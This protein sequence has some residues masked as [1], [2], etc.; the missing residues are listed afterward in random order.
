MANH[1]GFG[2]PRISN[3][4]LLGSLAA[5]A[6]A[7]QPLSASASSSDLNSPV[8]SQET[9]ER[10]NQIEQERRELHERIIETRQKE[11]LALL[12]LGHINTKLNATRDEL[13]HNTKKLERTE[14]KI[15]QCEQ[16]I[17]QTRTTEEKI[18]DT[19]AERLK[20]IY[21]GER[22]SFIEMVFQVDSLRSLID[23][24]YFQERVAEMDKK[25]LEELKTKSALLEQS[26]DK[27]GEQ[28]KNLGDVVSEFAKKAMQIAKE[29]F[30]Q[31]QTAEKLKT[32]RAFYEQAEKQLAQESQRLETEILSM[33]KSNRN[34]NKN[35][36]TGSGTLAM[37]LAA[38]ITSPFGWRRHPIFGV[39]KFHTG[40]DLAGANHSAIRAADSGSVLYTG[41]YGGYGKVVIVSHGKGLA[42]LY[43]HMSKTA[44]NVN[45]NVQ[46]GD[47]VGYEGTTGF[48][49]GPH[50]HFEVRVN[51]KPNNPLNFLK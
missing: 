17:N 3:R 35:M 19:A 4:I 23:R 28:K 6:V 24:M 34:A 15:N 1:F 49:T 22:L 11:Q 37:P 14:V 20:Q 25:V 31:E 43:A 44:V 7:L 12:K 48:S 2:H 47:I 29:K 16:N 30:A 32:Q 45:Q 18:S 46:K 27:L 41:W 51:G 21:E 39:R 33:E 13:R 10:L 40:I 8:V 50:L 42:T 38:H 36:L 9:K 26:K 5:A